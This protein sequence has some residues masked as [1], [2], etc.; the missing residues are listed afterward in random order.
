MLSYSSARLLQSE[1][2]RRRHGKRK[3]KNTALEKSKHACGWMLIVLKKARMLTLVIFLLLPLFNL[4][5][6]V[7]AEGYAVGVAT[8]DWMI[9]HVVVTGPGPQTPGPASI[10]VEVLNVVGRNVTL[11]LTLNGQNGTQTNQTITFEVG[12]TNSSGYSFVIPA[13]LT[14]G[15]TVSLN[16]GLRSIT[17][18]ETRICAGANRTVVEAAFSD[19]V[20]TYS[21]YFDKQTGFATDILEEH[22]GGWRSDTVAEDTNTWAAA[23]PAFDWSLWMAIAL[24]IVAAAVIIVFL[25]TRVR[26]GHKYS[27]VRGH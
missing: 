3:E 17:G 9:Y 8:G 22:S 21:Y 2:S 11:R 4:M 23:S 27:R 15:D 18:E 24:V 10:K 26:H 25:R 5:A 14:V 13:N 6:K 12:A 20:N 19:G 16:G 1:I 7:S